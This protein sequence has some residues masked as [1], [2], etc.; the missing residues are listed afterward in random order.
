MSEFINP[1]KTSVPVPIVVV[2]ILRPSSL[3]VY[4]TMLSL[5]D[6]PK[7]IL[8]IFIKDLVDRAGVS[9]SSF[10]DEIEPELVRFGFIMRASNNVESKTNPPV[11]YLCESSRWKLREI[12]DRL[13]EIG[14]P[15]IPTAVKRFCSRP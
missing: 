6:S 4:L 7:R 14:Y 8:P 12:A 2:M 15:D 10:R 5:C 9:G 3:K 1:L 13:S 11:F